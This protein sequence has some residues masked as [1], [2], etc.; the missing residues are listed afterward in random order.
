MIEDVA[1][2]YIAKE[3][4]F[5]EVMLPKLIPLEIHKNTGHLIQTQW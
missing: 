3:A 5:S 1:V 2:Q 4:G